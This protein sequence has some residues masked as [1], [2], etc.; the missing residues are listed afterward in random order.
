MLVVR[1]AGGSGSQRLSGLYRGSVGVFVFVSPPEQ[2]TSWGK[3]A[4]GD[5]SCYMALRVISYTVGPPR[6]AIAAL[7]SNLIDCALWKYHRKCLA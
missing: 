2:P 6:L 3:V 7:I 1:W 5:E 4:Q